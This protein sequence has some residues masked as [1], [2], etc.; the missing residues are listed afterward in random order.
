MDLREY[1]SPHGITL[2][3]GGALLRGI[4][5]LVAQQTGLTVHIAQKPL[6][7]VAD[8]AGKRLGPGRPRNLRRL[9]R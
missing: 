1:L 2:T 9:A 6:D 4:D 5:M 3:G 7:C 8:G